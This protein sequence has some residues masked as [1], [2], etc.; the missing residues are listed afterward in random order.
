MRVYQKHLGCSNNGSQ[1]AWGTIGLEPQEECL[2]YVHFYLL[3]SPSQQQS[4]HQISAFICV[5]GQ[6][7]WA[8]QTEAGYSQAAGQEGMNFG[9]SN[10]KH[11][12]EGPYPSK[13]RRILTDP[14]TCFLLRVFKLT[15]S[16]CWSLDLQR[17]PAGKTPPKNSQQQ[18]SH[19]TA[20]ALSVVSNGQQWR[21]KQH[22]WRLIE[23]HNILQKH[24]TVAVLV[25]SSAC[26]RW[27]RQRGMQEFVF[28]SSSRGPSYHLKNNIFPSLCA[29]DNRDPGPLFGKAKHTRPWT[30]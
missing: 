1:E 5:F 19:Q 14:T 23:A 26:L 27:G 4:F 2:F 29:A 21:K 24:E 9:S 10:R 20:E 7:V 25:R 6:K 15:V 22:R 11:S 28:D 16:Q 30:Q 13:H 12:L 18:E 3:S 8:E 17:C